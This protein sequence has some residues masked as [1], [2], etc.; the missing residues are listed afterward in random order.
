MAGDQVVIDGVW[1]PYNFSE[2]TP[3]G[4]FGQIFNSVLYAFDPLVRRAE[5]QPGDGK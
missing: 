1:H 5:R 2:E 3:N 4:R